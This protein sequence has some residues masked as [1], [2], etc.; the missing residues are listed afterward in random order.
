MNLMLPR[1]LFA[2][3]KLYL[4]NNLIVIIT[5]VIFIRLY[6]ISKLLYFSKSDFSIPS[7]SVVL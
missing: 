3:G 7:S 4:Y 2:K 1:L 5:S 6:V